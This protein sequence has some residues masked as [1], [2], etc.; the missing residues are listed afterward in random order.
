MIYKEDIEKI[1]EFIN[2]NSQELQDLDPSIGGHITNMCNMLE[3]ELEKQQHNNSYY[4]DAD[5]WKG[6]ELIPSGF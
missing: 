5:Q 2:S 6:F 1:R 4:G 3:I